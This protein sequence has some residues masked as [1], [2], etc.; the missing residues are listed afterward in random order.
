MDIEQHYIDLYRSMHEDKNTYQG[1][2]LFK[3]TPNIANIVLITNSQ[4][5]LDYGCGKGSQYTDSH[6]NILFHIN[7]ENIYMYDPGFPEHENIPEDKF[8]GVISTDVL[9]HIPEEIVPKIL[10][11]IYSKANKFV[12]LAICTRLAQAILPNGENAHCTVKEPDWWEKHIIKSNK[13]KIHTEVHWYGNHNDYRK[14][15]ISS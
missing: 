9:E 15:N 1:V 13:N 3:E 11:E 7:D 2:S 4:T 5:V 6:L 10:D 8:D 12:Y 14:Y